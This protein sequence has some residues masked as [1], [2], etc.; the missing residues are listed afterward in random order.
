MHISLTWQ[1]PTTVKSQLG[2]SKRYLDASKACLL[3][4][5]KRDL[6]QNESHWNDFHFL[7]VV[8]WISVLSHWRLTILATVQ[9]AFAWTAAIWRIYRTWRELSSWRSARSTTSAGLR[10]SWLWRRTT[11]TRRQFWVWTTRGTRSTVSASERI[12]WRASG[13]RRLDACIRWSSWTISRGSS[14]VRTWAR[15]RCRGRRTF[16]GCTARVG[17]RWSIYCSALT[18]RRPSRTRRCCAGTRSRSRSGRTWYRRKLSHY[19]RCTGRRGTFAAVCRPCRRSR[20]RWPHRWRR[21]GRTSSATWIQH[22]LKYIKHILDWMNEIIYI[23]NFS[24]R[25]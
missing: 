18:S 5:R 19:W 20:S 2:T 24:G 10:I 3:S 23:N 6:L 7:G 15:W 14:W 21:C 4:F 13:S 9:L 17:T 25:R 12:W 11:S 22:R 8:C 16:T 1:H